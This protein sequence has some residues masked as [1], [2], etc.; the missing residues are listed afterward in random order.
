[1]KSPEER[2]DSAKTPTCGRYGCLVDDDARE[3]GY[4]PPAPFAPP[5]LR[6]APLNELYVLGRTTYPASP[7]QPVAYPPAAADHYPPHYPPPPRPDSG[8]TPGQGWVPQRIDDRAARRRTVAVVVAVVLALVAVVGVLSVSAAGPSQ[9]S[10]SLPDTAG[11]YLRLSTIS[12]SQISS[13]IGSHG[14][15]G[16]IPDSDLAKAKIAIY[17]RGAQSVPRALFVGFDAADSPAIG[18]QLRSESAA[19]V[20]DSV[21]AGAGAAGTSV[22][23]DA[24]PLGGS[25]KCSSVRVAGLNATVGVWA[26][27]DTLGVVVLF[28]PTMGPSLPQTGAVTRTFRAQAEH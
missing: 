7:M 22:A 26:D 28:D 15:F 23:V 17:A 5:S 24:G 14:T 10:L 25:L 3:R 20:T 9:R 8:W 19:Q 13:I 4:A 6:G 18:G 12:S 27:S 1:V 16:S 21:L 11:P 2:R